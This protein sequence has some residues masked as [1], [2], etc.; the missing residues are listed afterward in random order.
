[1]D[2][3]R[4]VES[5]RRGEGGY[6]LTVVGGVG[7][8]ACVGVFVKVVTCGVESC[9]AAALKVAGPS[10]AFGADALGDGVAVGHCVIVAVVVVEDVVGAVGV[11]EVVAAAAVVVAVVVVV[12]VAP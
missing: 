6:A 2:R 11:V 5:Q 3:D 10:G 7:P 8:V 9:G 4:I 12:V 1:M